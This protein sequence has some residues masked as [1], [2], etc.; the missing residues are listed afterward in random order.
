MNYVF[1]T[2]FAFFNKTGFMKM[3]LFQNYSMDLKPNSNDKRVVQ[4]KKDKIF[5]QTIHQDLLA[6]GEDRTHDIQIA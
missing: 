6:P 3:S 4:S 5:N 2:Y 1:T